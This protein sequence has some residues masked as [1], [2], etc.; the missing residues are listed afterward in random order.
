MTNLELDLNQAFI[1][2][3]QISCIIIRLVDSSS[4]ILQIRTQ[5]ICLVL[6]HNQARSHDFTK[7]G[8][9]NLEFIKS[10]M[11]E[12]IKKL[13]KC[14]AFCISNTGVGDVPLAMMRLSTIY[15]TKKRF[16]LWRS[17]LSLKN[18]WD[19]AKKIRR[20]GESFRICLWTHYSNTNVGWPRLKWS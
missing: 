2:C 5:N 1:S 11:F 18:I 16:P 7:K 17:W 14:L 9:G 6:F 12:I 10:M 13:C 19:Y 8:G 3:Y 20:K 15:G 4:V